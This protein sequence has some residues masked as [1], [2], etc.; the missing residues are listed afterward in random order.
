MLWWYIHELRI[1]SNVSV[2]KKQMYEGLRWRIAL[3]DCERIGKKGSLRLLV[4]QDTGCCL[5]DARCWR[6]L[7]V[8]AVPHLLSCRITKSGSVVT[9]L[10]CSRVVNLQR[11]VCMQLRARLY[12]E[13]GTIDLCINF[14]MFP[15]RTPFGSGIFQMKKLY[16]YDGFPSC[17]I[18]YL[19][20]S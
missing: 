17:Q 10:W 20:G 11:I 19:P 16:M 6:D 7:G 18:C 13:E 12:Q 8:I 9:T 2:S 15:F 3:K 4:K 1:V 14:G 5:I